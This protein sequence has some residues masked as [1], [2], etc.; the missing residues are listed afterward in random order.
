MKIEK[1]LELFYFR[2]IFK[3]FEQDLFVLTFK[4]A[5]RWVFIKF[6]FGLE[7]IHDFQNFTRDFVWRIQSIAKI[8]PIM[9]ITKGFVF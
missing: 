7:I 4:R 2:K 9:K 8:Q 6:V 1:A 3:L 5:L